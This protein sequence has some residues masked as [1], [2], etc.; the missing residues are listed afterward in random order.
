MLF[1]FDF[2]CSSY[3]ITGPDRLVRNVVCWSFWPSLYVRIILCTSC[4][5]DN[6]LSYG[7]SFTTPALSEAFSIKFSSKCADH[8]AT[9]IANYRHTAA[10]WR[11]ISLMR[12]RSRRQRMRDTP[13]CG[14]A[15][16]WSAA[17]FAADS[18]LEPQPREDQVSVEMFCFT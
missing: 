5:L 13:T 16:S 4:R 1:P 10:R 18:R 11:S 17:S 3:I 9:P 7:V 12:E 2:I 6:R 15:I 14:A 8:C